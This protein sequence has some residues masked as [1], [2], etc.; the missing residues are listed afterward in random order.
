MPGKERLDCE[1]PILPSTKIA[2]L[3]EQ[4]PE[5]EDLLI[6]LAPP[7]QKL[8]NPILRRTVAKVASLQ[9][10]AAVG[11]IPVDELINRLRA[12]VGQEALASQ[13]TPSD[14]DSY[15]LPRPEWFDAARIVASIDE[16]KSDPN[17]MPIVTVLQRTAAL[18]PGQI[19]ELVT[20]Y[21]PAPG[22]D[23]LRKRNFLV[24][25][26]E[27]ESGLVRTYVSRRGHL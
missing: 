2:A 14:T 21:L 11:R 19:L 3:L 24:W 17:K 20:T 13:M 27:D 22:I 18:Q 23:I 7:F 4:Y 26:M 6:G 8:K 5:L 12:A 1:F 25:S 10:V 15:F 9:Q 16:K